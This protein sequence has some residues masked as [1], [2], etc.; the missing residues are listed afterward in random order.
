MVRQNK[1]ITPSD[2]QLQ[3]VKMP[4]NVMESIPWRRLVFT[5]ANKQERC[6]LIFGLFCT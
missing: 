5:Y 2:D 1:K 3:V 6:L 4:E